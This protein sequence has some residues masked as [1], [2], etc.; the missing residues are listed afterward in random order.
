MV[1]V[2]VVEEEKEEE[3]VVVVKVM[4]MVSEVMLVENVRVG[5]SGSSAGGLERGCWGS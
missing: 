1:V 4:L 2:L 3:K 5:G